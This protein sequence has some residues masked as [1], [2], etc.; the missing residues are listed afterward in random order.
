[1]A[2]EN[3]ATKY[4]VI[5]VP[6]KRKPLKTEYKLHDYTLAKVTS[7]KYLGETITEDLKRDT[8]I[9]DTCVKLSQQ[10]PLIPVNNSKVI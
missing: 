5:I 8:H 1:M 10:N 2:V 4:N 9:N 7:A 6:G 3:S